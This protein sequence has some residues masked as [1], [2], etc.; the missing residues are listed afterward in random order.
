LQTKIEVVHT[1]RP[2][3]AYILGMCRSFCWDIVIFEDMEQCLCV[4]KYILGKLI[5]MYGGYVI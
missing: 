2:A 3:M 4:K 5:C 1:D